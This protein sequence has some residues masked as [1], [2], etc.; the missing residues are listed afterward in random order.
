MYLH[1][2]LLPEGCPMAM[3]P[4]RREEFAPGKEP[5]G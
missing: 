2:R 4:E 5:R 1:T 3:S